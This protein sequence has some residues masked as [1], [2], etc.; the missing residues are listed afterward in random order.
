MGIVE[1]GASK[2]VADETARKHAVP[3]QTTRRTL[4]RQ[5]EL[6]KLLPSRGVGK[7]A[8]ELAREL[9]A[10]GFAVSKRQVERDLWELYEAF[11]LECNGANAPYGWKWP[12]GASLDLPAMS[13]AEALS[14]RLVQDAVQPLLPASLLS[15]LQPRFALAQQ[16]LDGLDAAHHQVGAWLQKVRSVLPT[17]PMLPAQV[18]ADVQ[19]AVHEALLL[20][21]Q[22]Q[23]TYQAAEAEKP[24]EMR[25]HPLG[26][27]NRG[28]VSY[29]IATAWDYED[30]RLYALQRIRA[31]YTSD[32]EAKRP[33]GFDID[34]YLARGALHFGS[35]SQIALRARVGTYL[36]RVLSETPLSNDQVLAGDLLTA[37]VND[38]WQLRWW[39]LSQGAGIEVLEPKSLREEIGRE[40]VVAIAAYGF[41]PSSSSARSLGGRNAGC[42]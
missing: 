41:A 30:V 29:L 23:M 13:V 35:E 11:H 37:T 3:A 10:E 31:A 26:L 22:L 33:Q 34:A 18:N 4:A 42:P 16:K 7:T 36:A 8:T 40:L 24:Q 39:I 14:L 9:N 28:H 15:A 25:V 38:T 1:G 5:W 27:V 6:L 19:D 20:D 32:Q 12:Q 2:C 17:Q 21:R